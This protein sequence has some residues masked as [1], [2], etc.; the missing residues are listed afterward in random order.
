MNIIEHYGTYKVNIFP[1]KPSEIKKYI[2]NANLNIK[3]KYE[4]EFAHIFIAEKINLPI[5]SKSP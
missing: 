1:D 2:N 3:T 4:T 5:I